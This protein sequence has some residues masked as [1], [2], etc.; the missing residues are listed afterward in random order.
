MRALTLRGQ[1]SGVAGCRRQAET[2]GE[3][4]R[5]AG[6][7]ADAVDVPRRELPSPRRAA[8]VFVIALKPKNKK[9]VRLFQLHKITEKKETIFE[10]LQSESH[11]IFST[12]AWDS[13]GS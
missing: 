11:T 7:H 13:D 8:E 1:S 6:H 4:F 3:R 9:G 2:C 12:R 5:R 10:K